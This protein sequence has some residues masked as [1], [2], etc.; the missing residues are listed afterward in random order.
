MNP[1]C[2]K[3]NSTSTCSRSS[4]FDKEIAE[5]QLRSPKL[6]EKTK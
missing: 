2:H 4:I 6:T 1:G 5:L 3:D